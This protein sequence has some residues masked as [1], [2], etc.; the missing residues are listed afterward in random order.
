MKES[1]LTQLKIIGA[2]YYA[3]HGVKPEERELGGKYEVDLELIYDARNAVINDDVKYALN[4]EEAVFCVSEILEGDNYNLVETIASEILNLLME[5]F[6]ELTEVTVR[7][8]KFSA[9]IR[10]FIDYIE[11]QQ[12]MKRKSVV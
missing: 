8:R 7:L 11:V 1:S 5:K 6:P 9:P 3:Y 4:Y 2:Q 12:N 10:H